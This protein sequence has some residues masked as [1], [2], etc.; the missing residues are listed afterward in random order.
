MAIPISRCRICGAADLEA[1]LSLGDMPPVNSFLSGP[2][3]IAAE[4][5][6]PLGDRLLRRVH[7]RPA[8]AHRLDPRDV[9]TDY[10]Y[11]SSMSETVVRWG[12]TLAERYASELSLA[13]TTWSP[14]SRATTAAS[15]GR[16]GHGRV[17]VGVEPAKNIA[18]VANREGVPTRA[19][20][21]NSSSR[22]ELRAELG[23]AKLI[24]AR[25]VVAHV[26]E[27]VDFIAGA[28]QLA[29]GRRRPPRRGAVPARH[30]RARSSSTPSTTSTSATSRSPRSSVCSGR[31]ASCSGTS[32]RSRCTAA[33]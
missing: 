7:P 27:V 14:S 28:A 21:F 6:H 12:E 33:R 2:A 31:P 13:R 11:F 4:R 26:P 32:R 10:I 30:G 16:S 3:D 25:N 23:P 24:I 19:E 22:G 5:R 17:L 1:V 29:R 20:F 18:E 15:C 8:D 9:F